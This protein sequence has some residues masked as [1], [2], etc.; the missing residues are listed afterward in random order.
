MINLGAVCYCFILI[1]RVFCFYAAR[2]RAR[3]TV[4][5]FCFYVSILPPLSHFVGFL[6]I[7]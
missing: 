5:S 2:P 3:F 4:F 7:L 6:I 1:C